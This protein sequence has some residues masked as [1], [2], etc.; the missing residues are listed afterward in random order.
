MVG[1]CLGPYGG[2]GGG[3]FLMCELPCQGARDIHFCC[4][5]DPLMPDFNY[6]R[7]GVELCGY[8]PRNPPS[9]KVVRL[10]AV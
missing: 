4:V 10:S 5:Y 3:L 7:S 9:E 1:L 6:G 2:P 8:E